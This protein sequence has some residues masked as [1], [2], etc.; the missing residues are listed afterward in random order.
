MFV[1]GL[2]TLLEGSL[3]DSPANAMI[4]VTDIHDEFGRLRCYFEEVKGRPD[5]YTFV[6]TAGAVELPPVMYPKSEVVTFVNHEPDGTRLAELPSA[7]L[8][9]LHAACCKMMEMAGAAEYVED[10]L[11]DMERMLE[12]GTLAG[13]GSSDIGM[14]LRMKGLW[15]GCGEIV[16]GSTALDVVVE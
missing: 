15:E 8:L 5:S 10:V 4:L 11:E 6:T 2:S 14:I 7:C 3:I 12:E 9:K 13:D 16:E 1:P